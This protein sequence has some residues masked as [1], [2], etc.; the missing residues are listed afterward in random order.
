MTIKFKRVAGALF[1]LGLCYPT[2]LA[3]KYYQRCT[4]LPIRYPHI[5]TNGFRYSADHFFD[6]PNKIKILLRG[7]S[8]APDSV[9]N[10]DAIFI[11]NH[12]EY[13]TKFFANVHPHINEKYILI[14]H[15]GD[16]T[17]PGAY[18]H[19]LNSEK[20]IAWYSCNVAANAHPKM[21][22][23][24][25]GVMGTLIKNLPRDCEEILGRVLLDI[26]KGT[27]KKT[28]LFY[29]NVNP[30]TNTLERGKPLDFLRNQKF[31]TMGKTKPYE[32]YLR[33]MATH[34]FVISPHGTGLDC[35][36]TWEA[37]TLG[38]IPVVKKS[39]LDILYEGLPVLIV[40]DWQKVT[41]EFLEHKYQEMQQRE[42]QLER[43]SIAYWIDMIRKHKDSFKAPTEQ[44]PQANS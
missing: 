43:L 14:S 40:D 23:I 38:C 19:Y 6:Q 12:P 21:K 32:E 41:E 37:L 22:P 11:K 18:A 35:Y 26:K 34:K 42:Y 15:Q 25:L 17:T 33:E 24:P 28:K 5:S 39:S 20:I 9:K 29:F 16:M 13:L 44:E 31:C 4:Y 8:F 27:I 2:H 30:K 7:K 3:Y 10:G 1:L 36:R